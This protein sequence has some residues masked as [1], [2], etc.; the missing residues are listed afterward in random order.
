MANTKTDAVI[1]QKT[2]EENKSQKEIL[3]YL[4]NNNLKFDFAQNNKVIYEEK[5]LKIKTFIFDFDAKSNKDVNESSVITLL[6][7]KNKNVLFMADA[8]VVAFEQIEKY[9]PEKIDIIKI[10]HHGAK[11][12]VNDKMLNR[13]KP[14]WALISVGANKFNL[15]DA[16][17]IEK[18]L[19]K[20]IK[21][22]SSKNYGFSKIKLKDD[23]IRLYHF[24]GKDK[25]LKRIIFE[26][27]D[28]NLLLNQ[29]NKAINN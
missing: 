28:K 27:K 3:D 21:M 8:G 12:S 23:D 26:N 19:N 6:T 17:V 14:D 5:D 25:K 7:Y 13:I 2:L 18:L 9:L 10:G 22:V 24:D 15:P 11:N 1:L 20:N 16:C 4:K 29:K